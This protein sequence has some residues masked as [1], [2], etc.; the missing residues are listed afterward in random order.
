MSL[1]CTE[2]EIHS[3]DSTHVEIDRK[4]CLSE[5]ATNADKLSYQH[6]QYCQ[7]YDALLSKQ[8]PSCKL[9]TSQTLTLYTVGFQPESP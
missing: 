3:G 6:L 7:Q 4:I 2:A 8:S 9:Y 1:S 5:C